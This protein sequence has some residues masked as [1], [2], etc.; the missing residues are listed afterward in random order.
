[1]RRQSSLGPP[2]RTGL[3]TQVRFHPQVLVWLATWA[4]AF[5]AAREA[6]PAWIYW[7]YGPTYR[8]VDFVMGAAEENAGVPLVRGQLEPL[9][10]PWVMGLRS[11]PAG[12]VLDSDPAIAHAPGRRIRVWWSDAAPV[13]GYRGHSTKIMPTSAFP[14]VPGLLSALAWT[15]AVLLAFVAGLWVLARLGLRTRVRG[16]ETLFD[17]KGESRERD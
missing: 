12:Y 4:V 9:G 7:H 2:G 16:T 14:R 15:G 8:Q 11:T 5:F 17:G 6:I 10:E 3:W 13:V 1:M